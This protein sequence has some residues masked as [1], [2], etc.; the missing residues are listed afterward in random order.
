MDLDTK[1]TLASAVVAAQHEDE[2]V[3]DAVGNEGA[4]FLTPAAVARVL[5]LIHV[6]SLRAELELVAVLDRLCLLDAELFR[7][8]L[9]SRLVSPENVHS[10]A[11]GS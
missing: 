9:H 1:L 11:N 6:D 8:E 7:G 2:D 10:L 5:R 4:E 3:L